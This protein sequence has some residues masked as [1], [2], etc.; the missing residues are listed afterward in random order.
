MKPQ[1]YQEMVQWLDQQIVHLNKSINEA[2]E[3]NNWGRENQ[4]EGMRDAFIRC[5]NMLK[6]AL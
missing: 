5:L 6:K 1:Q 4:L 3:G 2:H